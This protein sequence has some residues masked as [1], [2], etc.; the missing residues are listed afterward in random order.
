MRACATQEC[1]LHSRVQGV[2]SSATSGHWL[3]LRLGL[4]PSCRLGLSRSSKLEI[5]LTGAECVHRVH[6][7]GY[8]GHRLK[9][10]P[11]HQDGTLTSLVNPGPKISKQKLYTPNW[12]HR[13]PPP[14]PQTTNYKPHTAHHKPHTT[15]RTPHTTNH[16]PAS[17]N[18]TCFRRPP[19]ALNQNQETRN[20]TL[21]ITPEA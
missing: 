10:H 19:Y 15:H 8:L 6:G 18:T 13:T 12:Y 21:R 5:L 16:K 9:L 4:S 14:A 17:T 7:I 3:V 1:I 2:G 11:R 20:R